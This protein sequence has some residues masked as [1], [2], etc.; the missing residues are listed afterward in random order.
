MKYVRKMLC[1]YEIIIVAI[2]GVL[3]ISM[4]ALTVVDTF[5]RYVFN[6]PLSWGFDLVTR[7]LLVGFFFFSFSIALR[8]G[9]HV[10]VDYFVNKFPV[11]FQRFMIAV[12]WG[13]CGLIAIVITVLSS[14]Q[15]IDAWTNAEVIAGVVPWPVW[16]QKVII[17]I[18][19]FPLAV[20]LML[21]CLGYMPYSPLDAQT[22]N[23]FNLQK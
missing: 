13:L 10:A 7:Y 11:G 5:M 20:R 17:P 8:M 3:L 16:V 1:G 22:K 23:T 14:L 2:A 9:E 6:A 15:T 4:M 12:A 18:A 21:M 19:F